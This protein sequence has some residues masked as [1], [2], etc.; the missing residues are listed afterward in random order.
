VPI[1]TSYAAAGIPKW[2]TQEIRL[3]EGNP[4]PAQRR[5]NEKDKEN[6]EKFRRGL[7]ANFRIDDERD[8]AVVHECDLHHGAEATGGDGAA[9]HGFKLT[10]EII[11]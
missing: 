10:D 8:R 1:W 6:N 9:E 2:G 7:L 11:V 3:K 5:E 4:V